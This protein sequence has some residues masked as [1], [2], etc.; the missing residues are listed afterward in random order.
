MNQIEISSKFIYFCEIYKVHKFRFNLVK[1]LYYTCDK[2]LNLKKIPKIF[3][4]K[5]YFYKRFF[6]L[7]SAPEEN[8][9]NND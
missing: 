7:I 3:K 5:N 9:I 4:R 8:L 2:E 1:E 6:T